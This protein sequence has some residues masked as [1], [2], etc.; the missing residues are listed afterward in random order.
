MKLAL[1]HST[2]A[3]VN[4]N[5]PP[6]PLAAPQAPVSKTASPKSPRHRRSRGFTLAEVLAA[7][8]F[9]A[10]VIPVSVEGV[11]L[12]NRAGVVAQR[13]VIAARLADNLLNELIASGRWQDSSQSGFFDEAPTGF[14]WR[15]QNEPW[16][17]DSMR[18]LTVEVLF[19]VQNTEYR[20]ALS[21]VVDSLQTSSAPQQQR[22]QT[23]SSQQTRP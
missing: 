19:D 14:R 7:L 17:V 8:L 2:F 23:Q 12:A 9:M 15:L 22:Q 6:T 10:I 20:V 4:P 13:K 3:A 18:L 11:R 5:P 16:P 21:T 1:C